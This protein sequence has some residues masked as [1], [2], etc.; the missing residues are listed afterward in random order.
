MIRTMVDYIN[1]CLTV[2]YL[3]VQPGLY[4]DEVYGY[5]IRFP[6]GWA[7]VEDRKHTPAYPAAYSPKANSA[8]YAEMK[9]IVLP[10]SASELTGAMQSNIAIARSVSN[11]VKVERN[12]PIRI[13]GLTGQVVQL[14]LSS[15]G[16]G[17]IRLIKYG[18]AKNNRLYFIHCFGSQAYFQ[19]SIQEI[20]QACSSFRIK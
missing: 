2:L 20:Q 15:P 1:T 10:G 17:L 8:D 5:S 4:T 7:I 11:D 16:L 19:Q 12:Q 18:F 13:G 6:K 3:L 9:V 14:T